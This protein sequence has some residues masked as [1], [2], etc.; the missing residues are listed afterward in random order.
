MRDARELQVME[1]SFGRFGSKRITTTDATTP[2]TGYKFVAIQVTEDAIFNAL[3]GNMVN[4]TGLS[5]GAGTII[6]GLFTSITLTSG[7]VIAYMGV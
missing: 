3:V 1:T 4:P 5:L 7:K 6:Y 2:T